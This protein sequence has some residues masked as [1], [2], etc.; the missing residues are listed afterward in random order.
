MELLQLRYFLEVARTQH[1]TRSAERLHIAQPSLSQSIKRLEA[2]LGVPLFSTRG[3][4][5]VLTEYGKFLKEKLEPLMQRLDAL[6]E[7]L[8]AMADP[9]QTTICLHVTAASLIVTEAIIEYRRMHEKVNFRF[10]LGDEA[11]MYDVSIEAEHGLRPQAMSQ[12]N[13]FTCNERIFLAVPDVDR[14]RRLTHVRLEDFRDA[15]FISLNSGHP[16]WQICD[17]FCAEA[18]FAPRIAF[19]SDSPDTVRNMIAARMG[20]GFWPAFSWGKLQPGRARML[21]I[22][23]PQCRRSIVIRLQRNRMDSRV[24]EDFFSFLGDFFMARMSEAYGVL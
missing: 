24:V 9:E 7:Q 10:L 14:F 1:I 8:Q 19:E 13:S 22:I 18:G 23:E 16:F 5:I 17:R 3:R 6:P 21:E 20:V 15:S 2:E 4:N 12:E 11:H